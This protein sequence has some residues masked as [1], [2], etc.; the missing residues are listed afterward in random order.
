MLTMLGLALLVGMHHALEADHVAAVSSLVSGRTRVS[1]IVGHGL[2]WGAG[3]TLTL[4]LFAGAALA[5]GQ[6]IPEIYATR[7]EAAVG[8]MLVGLGV[9]VLWRLW[10]D[11]IH[12][13]AHHHDG[14][15]AHFHAH[16][17][18]G[19]RLR[20]ASSPHRHAHRFKWRALAVGM[21]H[22]MAGSAA[23]LLLTVAQIGSAWEGLAYVVVF[24]L[25]SMVGMAVV[26]AAIGVP[27]TLS[28]Q[29]FTWANRGLQVA[30][31][32]TTIV[33]GAGTLH[34][35]INALKMS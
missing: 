6:A 15:K 2:T 25:G 4:F 23:L 32:V 33:I 5:F 3:H 35:A 1:D 19:E 34:T 17:H 29:F 28:A 16:S 21:M 9:H 22:G 14:G 13:H 30:I 11:R 10:R 8:L 27:L 31:A 7:L 20:H 12:F 26:S 18:A 24:G